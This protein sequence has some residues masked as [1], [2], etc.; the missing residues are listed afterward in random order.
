MEG[1]EEAWREKYERDV[2]ICLIGAHSLSALEP[3]NQ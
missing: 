2:M 1:S 3:Q